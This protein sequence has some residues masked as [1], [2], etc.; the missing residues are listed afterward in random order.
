M[1]KVRFEL[2]GPKD[3]SLCN[4]GLTM[5]PPSL[6]RSSIGKVFYDYLIVIHPIEHVLLPHEVMVK[7]FGF[8]LPKYTKQ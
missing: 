4:C 2:F 1:L 7:I 8:R 3:V 5:K 6:D